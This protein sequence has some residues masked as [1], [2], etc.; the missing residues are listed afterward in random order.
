MEMSGL[1]AIKNMKVI[2]MNI[3]TCSAQQIVSEISSIVKQ[4]VNMMD[5]KGYIIASTDS[6]RIGNFHEGAK[7][8]IDEHLREFYVSPELE[9]TMTRAGLNL[10][11]IINDD[12]IGVIG[13]TGEYNQVFN[14]GQIVKKMTEILVREN[15]TRDQ[16][17]INEEIKNRF[18]E[19]WILEASLEQEPSLIEKGMKLHIDV[20]RPRRVIVLRI[21]EFQ[22]LSGT[23]EGQKKIERVEKDIRHYLCKEQENQFLRLS[24]KQVCLITPRSDARMFSMGQEMI[25]RI[26]N[27]FCVQLLIGID[28]CVNG[29][30]EVRN[31]Y[32]K[33]NKASHACTAP[34]RTI[35]FYD[36]INME[37]FIEEIPINLKKEYLKKIFRNCSIEEVRNWM[38]ILEIYFSAEGSINQTANRLFMHKNTLQ[39]KLKRLKDYTGYDVRLPSNSAIFYMSMLFFREVNSDMLPFND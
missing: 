23:E 37:I 21:E 33:A 15:L 7:K 8:I 25:Q 22:Q 3:S 11:I 30:T 32:L 1:N 16:E 39:Y 20:T 29:T 27:K 12:I 9:T 5:Q 26:K 18:L 10:P 2:G 38:R 6:D 36:Q 4:N 31:S 28:N 35:R 13:I 17:R 19:S 14:Y 34:G 24:S